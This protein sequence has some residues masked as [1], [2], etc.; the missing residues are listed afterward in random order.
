MNGLAVELSGKGVAV[1]I[2]A[3]G[4]RWMTTELLRQNKIVAGVV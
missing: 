3:T 1:L 4:L 2:I